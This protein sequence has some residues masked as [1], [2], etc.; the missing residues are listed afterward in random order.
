MPLEAGPVHVSGKLH[1]PPVGNCEY[2]IRINLIISVSVV[3]ALSV[4]G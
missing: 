1:S 3:V 2:F 4:I